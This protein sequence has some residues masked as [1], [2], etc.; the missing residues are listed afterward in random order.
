MRV[1]LHNFALRLLGSVAK[2]LINLS[3]RDPVYANRSGHFVP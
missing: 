1:A 3:A 2:R